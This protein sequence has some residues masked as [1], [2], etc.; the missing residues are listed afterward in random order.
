MHEQQGLEQISRQA[1]LAA[2]MTVS[3]DV[4]WGRRKRRRK[5][6]SAMYNYALRGPRPI[7]AAWSDCS[8]LTEISLVRLPRRGVQHELDDELRLLAGVAERVGHPPRDDHHLARP[9]QQPLLLPPARPAA[10]D[11]DEARRPAHDAER[12]VLPEVAVQRRRQRG[13]GTGVREAQP[14]GLARRD[15]GRQAV[16]DEVAIAGG[17][18][19]DGGAA[20]VEGDAVQVRDVGPRWV[21]REEGEHARQ[22]SR[23][24]SRESRLGKGDMWD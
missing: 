5:Y 6:W 7:L 11:G 17:L 12:L 15:G 1:G 3:P 16:D 13:V 10:R 8:V 14:L 2:V 9:G 18:E 21:L 24:E 19:H 22:E 23:A 20:A 4:S